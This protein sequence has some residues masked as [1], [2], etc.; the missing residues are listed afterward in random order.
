MQ[1]RPFDPQAPMI[2]TTSLAAPKESDT[3]AIIQELRLVACA[4]SV[5]KVLLEAMARLPVHKSPSSWLKKQSLEQAILELDK[6]MYSLT[7]KDL[8]ESAIVDQRGNYPSS[9]L[10]RMC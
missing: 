9:S 10:E 7:N 1:D 5:D 2:A 6:H 8:L 3:S 4:S